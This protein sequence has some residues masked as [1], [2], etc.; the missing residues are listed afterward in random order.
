[1]EEYPDLDYQLAIRFMLV[2]VMSVRDANFFI[3][4]LLAIYHQNNYKTT[5]TDVS[6]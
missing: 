5:V 6:S 1:M 3:T 4:W 2:R